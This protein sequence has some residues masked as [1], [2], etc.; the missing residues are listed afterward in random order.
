MENASKA[1]IMAAGVLIA[2]LVLTLIVYLYSTFSETKRANIEQLNQTQLDSFNGKYLAYDG[3][4]D[5][6]Y[7]DIY[8]VTLMA[9]KDG[10]I[11]QIG[12]QK[13]SIEPKIGYTSIKNKLKDVTA[14]SSDTDPSIMDNFTEDTDLGTKSYKEL[15]KYK[16]TVELDS[17][18]GKVKLVK[19]N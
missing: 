12:S 9:E 5:L 11:V 17:G 6:T 3:R 15:K 8:N 4:K 16:C 7:Y 13:L 10:I 14:I 1:L 19:F 2:V 18:T